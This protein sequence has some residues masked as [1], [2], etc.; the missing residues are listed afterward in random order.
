MQ[1]L[2]AVVIPIKI[3]KKIKVIIGNFNLNN[4]PFEIFNKDVVFFLNELSKEIMMNNKSKKFPDLISFGFW[5]RSSNISA[6]FKNYNFFKNRF[7]RG[8]VF[9]ITPSNVPTNFAYSLVFGLLSG[10][11]NIIRL[12]SKNFFQVKIF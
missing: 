5:C 6:L 8:T 12:P 3:K 1:N 10:N 11:N 7:G 9:H 2:E 4:S